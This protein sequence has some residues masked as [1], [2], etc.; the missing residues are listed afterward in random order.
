[1]AESTGPQGAELNLGITQGAK[2]KRTITAS[3]N[4]SAIDL[5]N[6]SFEAQ[7]RKKHGDDTIVATF[8]VTVTDAINGIFTIELADSVTAAI[9]VDGVW[10]LFA[11]DS[12]D[13]GPQRWMFGK[14]E[15]FRRTTV[16]VP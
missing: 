2:F 11:D 6:Y 4:G 10:D 14:V 15:I 12:A 8:T 13:P 5:T 16:P 9:E 3:Q 1:M 7:I